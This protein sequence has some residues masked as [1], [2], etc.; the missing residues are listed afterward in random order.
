MP[1]R[2]I[3]CADGTW[4]KV[5]KAQS[6]KHLSTNVAKLA[7]ALLPVDVH[8]TTQLLCYFEG[9]GTHPG[10]WLRGGMFGLGIS[11]NIE[12]AYT[13]LVQSYNPEDEIWIVGSVA[14]LLQHEE[15]PDFSRD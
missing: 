13:F 11:K 2:L 8:G 14:E 5:E 4:N 15:M 6:G 3:V 12:R 10:E 9:V 1:K 7:A